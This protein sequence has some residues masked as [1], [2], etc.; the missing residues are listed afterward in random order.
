MHEGSAT[1]LRLTKPLSKQELPP[2]M[3]L[4]HQN[5]L[6]ISLALF[7]AYAINKH[8]SAMAAKCMVI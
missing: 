8:V 4:S 3:R 5:V 6:I 2:L 1:A 7:D